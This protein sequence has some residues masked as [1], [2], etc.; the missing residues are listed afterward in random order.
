LRGKSNLW[1]AAA[2]S[3]FALSLGVAATGSLAQSSAEETITVSARRVTESQYRHAIRD[4][5]GPDIVINGRFE[6]DRREDGLQAVG[7]ANLSITPS[8]FEQYFAMARS[9]GDQV[10]DPKRRE[11]SVPC[12]PA[13]PTKPDDA[14]AT[15]FVRKYGEP[16]FRRPLTEAEVAARVKTAAAGAQGDFYAGLKLALTSLLMAPEHLF[17]IERAE[18]D[19]AHPDRYRL[20]GYARASRLSYLFWDAPPDKELLAAAQS[21]ELQTPEGLQR[22]IARLAASPRLQEGARA[23]F[24]DMLQMDSYD[25][26]VK[27]PA[28]Y[29]KFSQAVADAAREQTLRTIVDLLVVKKRDYRDIFTSNE[30]FINRA[31][32][33]VYNVPYASAEE[34][35][36]YAFPASSERS[37]IF[38]EVGFLSVFSHPGASSPTKRG[39]KINEIFLC[40]PTP[41]PPPNVDFSKVQALDHGTVR[42]RLLDH[43]SNPGCAACHRVSDPVGLTLEHFD[44]LG[45]LRT[46]ENGA[47]IDVSAEIGSAKF[48]GAQ[49]LG[50]YLHDNPRASS[51]LVR[52]AFAYGQGRPVDRASEG[53][54]LDAQTKAFADGGYRFPTLLTNLA[55]SPQFFRVVLPAGA[56]PPTAQVAVAQA[57]P[58]RGAIR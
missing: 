56:K 35:A 10:L 31:L 50:Q 23:F 19:P 28:T 2:A 18:I 44:G 13:D 46:K 22:Q 45:Q 33:A 9:I 32:A 4:I 3:A 39:V 21:G 17:R 40:Q 12:K 24:T 11:A 14:C 29:P 54:F 58:S 8:G 37:G 42:T 6:P 41:D 36:P 7:S 52:N 27:D 47:L 26:L 43:M 51:C 30:T 57:D 34:W 38:T 49:G 16:L 25:A 48:S 55:T 53:G 20:D 1:A 15:A 5:F